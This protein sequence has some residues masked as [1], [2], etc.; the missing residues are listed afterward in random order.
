MPKTRLNKKVS[1]ILKIILIIL[2]FV[3]IIGIGLLV[4]KYHGVI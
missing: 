1:R 2:F 4:F 3:V